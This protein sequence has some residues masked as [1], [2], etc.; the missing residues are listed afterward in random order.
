[1][2]VVTQ[3]FSLNSYDLFLFILV[4]RMK[5]LDYCKIVG[6]NFNFVAQDILERT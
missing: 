5:Q 4:T 1:M 3:V 6:K 2:V